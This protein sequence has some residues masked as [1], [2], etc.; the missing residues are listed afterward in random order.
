MIRVRAANIAGDGV[1]GNNDSTDQDFALVVYNGESKPSPVAKFESVVFS[2]GGDEFADPGET[3]SLNVSIS[4][5]STVA[6]I[7]GRGTISTTTAGVNVTTNAAD[8][9]TIAQGETRENLTPF[10]LTVDKSVPCGTVIPFTLD[11]TSGGLISRIRF[12][13]SLG[14]KQPAEFFTDSVESG[15]SKWTHASALKKKKKKVPVDT[16][17]ISKKRFRSGGSAWFSS[18]PGQQADAHLDSIQITLPADGRNLELVF[19]HTFEF[20]RGEFDGGVIE[21]STGGNFEDLG[22]KFIRGGYNGRIWELAETNPLAG[23]A[24]W[25]QG[26]LGQFQQVVVDLSSFA[27]KTVVI[28]FRMVTDQDIKGLGWYIDDISLRGDRVSCTPVPL[29]NE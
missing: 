8:F 3:I 27:G 11:V 24:A 17:S 21:I 10:V 7:G 28:R 18:D 15:E 14:R 13:L 5:P 20:E 23:E 1:P 29:A 19:Y 12:S 4:D 25:T 26:R 9:P 22:S 16:W 6:L 2:G